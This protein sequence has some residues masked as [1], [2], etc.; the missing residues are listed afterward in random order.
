MLNKIFSSVLSRLCFSIASFIIV[1]ATTRVLGADVRGDI[2]LFVLSVTIAMTVSSIAGGPSLVYLVPRYDI[3]SLV[4]VCYAWAMVSCCCAAYLL[5]ELNLLSVHLFLHVFFISLLEAVAKIHLN[6]LAGTEKLKEINIATIG[7]IALQLI[8]FLGF[9][10]VIHIDG[11]DSYLFALYL[12]NGA[13][14]VY[15]I[16]ASK[17]I[18]RMGKELF[19]IKATV[20]IFKF[21]FFV[22]AGNFIQLLNYRISYFFLD[23]FFAKGRNMVGIYSTGTSV[24]EAF[25]FFSRGV[26]IV[27]YSKIANTNN[28]DYSRQLSVHL[29]K[30]NITGIAILMLPLIFLPEEFYRWLFGDEFGGVRNI[31]L[32]LSPGILAFAGSGALSHY[33][34]GTGKHYVNTIG[35]AIG[36]I[37]TIVFGLIL[38]PKYHITGAAITTVF[39]HCSSTLFQ[40]MVFLW[41]SEAGIKQFL[42][43]KEDW[44]FFKASLKAFLEKN[45]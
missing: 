15:S 1:I 2:S 38:I 37:I 31:V 42:P 3:L 24:A 39:S 41:K 4:S 44:T 40:L 45:S 26:S 21:G 18:V 20:A 35:S 36:L 27:Q 29:F 10:F 9:L 28:D 33:F 8:L 32:I 6:L 7:Q 5:M 25:W 11:F 43:D 12:S 14:V 16:I 17:S 23:H 19:N 34:S 22:Q 30:L 13:M